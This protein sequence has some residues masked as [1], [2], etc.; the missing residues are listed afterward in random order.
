MRKISLLCF[1]V[2]FFSSPLHAQHWHMALKRAEKT[3][4]QTTKKYQGN[5][6]KALE[7]NISRAQAVHKAF[8]ETS[9]FTPM[10]NRSY[11]IKEPIGMYKMDMVNGWTLEENKQFMIQRVIY[12]R[13]SRQLL[14]ANA[15]LSNN[16]IQTPGLLSAQD[17]AKLI[18][19][20]KKYIF[21]GEYHHPQITQTRIKNIFLWGNTTIPKLPKRCKR[22]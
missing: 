14:Q 20:D 22:R 13:H 6:E 11:S 16:N 7:K 10:F 3:L 8:G 18:P 9:Y 2:L 5:I 21:M 1:A 15:F 12:E 19:A 17:L 4:R